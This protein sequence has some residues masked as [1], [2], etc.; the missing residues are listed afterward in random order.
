MMDQIS[1]ESGAGAGASEEDEKRPRTV[2]D[3][4]LGAIG[5]LLIVLAVVFPFVGAFDDGAEAAPPEYV[6]QLRLIT[7]STGETV[8]GPVPLAFSTDADLVYGPGGWGVRGLH[9]H[10]EVDGREFMPSR[11]DITRLPDG[12]YR[13]TLRPLQRGERRLRLLWSDERHEPLA[14]GASDPIKIQVL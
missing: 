2:P 13:W 3:R 4:T 7:P 12:S 9:L 10:V 1:L 14:D 8:A 11:D 5:I 6:P